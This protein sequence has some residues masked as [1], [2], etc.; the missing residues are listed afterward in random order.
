MLTFTVGGFFCCPIVMKIRV[1]KAP[2]Q[3][4]LRTKSETSTINTICRE[5]TVSRG[6]YRVVIFAGTVAGGK[7]GKPKDIW[8][9]PFATAN[10][11]VCFHVVS[12]ESATIEYFAHKPA[13]ASLPSRPTKMI[14]IDNAAPEPGL[15]GKLKALGESGRYG[16]Y[17]CEA[18]HFDYVH[19]LDRSLA[20]HGL[21]AYSGYH[22]RVS[23]PEN[24]PYIN[25]SRSEILANSLNYLWAVPLDIAT[26]PVAVPAFLIWWFNFVKF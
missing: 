10:D 26:M 8:L 11:A 3:E 22:A 12:E 21:G 4:F 5:G 25:R 7:Q 19:G 14:F 13:A 17:I 23:N 1:L 2:Y 24:L 6:D 16:F 20:I 15:E 18:N 9:L